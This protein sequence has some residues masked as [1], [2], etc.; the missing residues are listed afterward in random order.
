MASRAHEGGRRSRGVVSEAILRQLDNAEVP[1]Q[2]LPA[3]VQTNRWGAGMLRHYFVL[4]LAGLCEWHERLGHPQASAW[5][6]RVLRRFPGKTAFLQQRRCLIWT[7]LDTTTVYI[8]AN[9]IRRLPPVQALLGIVIGT[10]SFNN[11]RYLS[12]IFGNDGPPQPLTALTLAQLHA[13]ARV[14][15]P[16]LRLAPVGGPT[17]GSGRLSLGKLASQLHIQQK[18]GQN[19]DQ[20]FAFVGY[21]YAEHVSQRCATALAEIQEIAQRPVGQGWLRLIKDICD[22]MKG[23]KTQK[24]KDDEEE[25][26]GK[27]DEE[28]SD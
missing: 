28:E 20:Y 27:D 9:Y 15:D 16:S 12:A 22:Y 19:A 10:I 3:V 26:K 24:G 2:A 8:V 5:K 18:T 13:A 11:W 7:G 1:V 23:K 21:L 25:Q 4:L 17:T 6:A 14:K